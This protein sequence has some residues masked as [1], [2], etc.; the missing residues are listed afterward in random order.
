MKKKL[1]CLLLAVM[2]IFSVPA[3]SASAIEVSDI[4]YGD[5]DGDKEVTS[6]D[7]LLTL[8]ASIGKVTFN[9]DQKTAGDV[10]FD[11][12]ITSTDAQWILQGSVSMRTLGWGKIIW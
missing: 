11:K 6:I 7:A 1:L 2:M 4:I 12:A 5:V 10:D 8:N 9:E 3:V